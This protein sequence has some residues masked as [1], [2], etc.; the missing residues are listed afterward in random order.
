MGA[1]RAMVPPRPSATPRRHV[2][3]PTAVT[4][5]GRRSS[6][7]AGSSGPPT[8]TPD[9]SHPGRHDRRPPRSPLPEAA[10]AA[11]TAA[12]AAAS[13]RG[14]RHLSPPFRFPP[15]PSCHCLLPLSPRTRRCTHSGTGSDGGGVLTPSLPPPL[16]KKRNLMNQTPAVELER[17]A[18]KAA[19]SA[20][21]VRCPTRGTS[22][23]S[24]TRRVVAPTG[25]PVGTRWMAGALLRL[26][27]AGAPPS[28]AGHEGGWWHRGS[29]RDTRHTTRELLTSPLLP[30]GMEN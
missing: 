22:V 26:L 27:T 1:C 20:S 2:P 11:N 23:P 25:I 7:G 9:S 29:R 8:S 13:I 6:G 21:D 17:L 19:L 16:H 28:E 15:P 30:Y 18:T 5:K 14:S 12:A 24:V 4:W 3:G 10:A